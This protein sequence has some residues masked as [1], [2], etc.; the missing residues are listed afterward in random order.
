MVAVGVN[1]ARLW[2]PR[3][4]WSRGRINLRQLSAVLAAFDEA[5]NDDLRVLVAHH[6]FLLVPSAGSR[7][8]VGRSGL[9]PRHL[10]RRADLLLGGHL[11]QAYS[12]LADG[13]VV[14]QRGTAFSNRTSTSSARPFNASTR[15]FAAR[16]SRTVREK[17]KSGIQAERP[18][19]N[20]YRIG[21]PRPSS[22]MAHLTVLTVSPSVSPAC[23]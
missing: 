11:Y 12:G 9:A 4:D 8:L 22:A 2:G 1:T 13:L 10:R 14:A 5:P 23:R 3:T 21:P 6:P 18:G 19:R 20:N 7:G 17:S 15:S 16:P